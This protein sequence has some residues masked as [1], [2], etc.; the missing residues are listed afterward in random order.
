MNGAS[1]R[2]II[3]VTV[4]GIKNEFLIIINIELILEQEEIWL[5]RDKFTLFSS[6]L[7]LSLSY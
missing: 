5:T 6:F 2:K 7:F 1:Q 4:A 3:R